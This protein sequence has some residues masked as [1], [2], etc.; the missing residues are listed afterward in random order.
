MN[1][2][3][4]KKPQTSTTLTVAEEVSQALINAKSLKWHISVISGRQ[5][6]NFRLKAF[7]ER[8]LSR[9]AG[10]KLRALRNS[11][12]A[13]EVFFWGGGGLN[14]PLSATAIHGICTKPTSAKMEECPLILPHR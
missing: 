5:V 2:S 8:L 10:G 12:E 14:T 1:K 3:V 4:Y 6:F 11:D 13:T 9:R 7:R